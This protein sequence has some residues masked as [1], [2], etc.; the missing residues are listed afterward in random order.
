MVNRPRFKDACHTYEPINTNIS[1]T[2]VEE[3]A[4]IDA[5]RALHS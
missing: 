4:R 5:E 3:Y 2:I 1:P